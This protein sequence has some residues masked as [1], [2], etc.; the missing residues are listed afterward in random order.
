MY[1]KI[2][3]IIIACMTI[4]VTCA[5]IIFPEQVLRASIHGL[6]TWWEIVFPSLLPFFIVAE[7]L[8]CFGI[9]Q[10]FGVLFEPIMRPIFN[11]PGVG[12]FAWILGMVS[13]FP[14]GAKMTVILREKKAISQIEGERLLTF[15]NASSPLFIF[16]AIAVGFFHHVQLGII[17]AISHYVSNIIVGMIMKY[18]KF[19]H[20]RNR[21]VKEQ[22][23]D[24]HII[25]KA[26]AEMHRTRIAETRPFGEL[27]GD[28]VLSSIQTLLMIGGFII[29]FSVFTTILQLTNILFMIQILLLP[30]T[31]V[32]SIQA[33]IIPTMI[34]GLF[35]ITIGA[36]AISTLTSI[37]LVWQLIL[38]SFVLGFNGFSI[39]AQVAS[40][41]AKT[42]LRFMPYF[43]GRIVHAIIASIL[44]FFSYH[45]YFH[46]NLKT[47]QT[48]T[49]NI[50]FTTSISHLMDIFSNIGPL[51]TICSMFIGFLIMFIRHQNVQ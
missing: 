27:I 5:I 44:T 33:E 26:F 14:S 37:P 17:I 8:T 18:Y 49:I 36:E 47:L 13:G 46:D 34:T 35:E 39:Q 41:I 23:A 50:P 24:Y 48:T 31:T 42:D 16:G 20:K 6:H 38:I 9:V 1:A 3:T 10:F 22:T 12:S 30:I 29:L 28:A 25:R 21:D 11:V 2:K 43:Y 4:L 19:N 32:L 51:I 40:L 45:F 7:L 15:S